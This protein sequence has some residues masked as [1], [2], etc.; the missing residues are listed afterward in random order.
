[1]ETERAEQIK[2]TTVMI[3]RHG[4]VVITG[5][6][7]GSVAR[8]LTQVILGRLLGAEKYG[9]YALGFSFFSIIGQVS[10]L[11]LA[12]G[13]IKYGAVYQS[14]NDQ[15]RLKGLL[16]LAVIVV[17]AVAVITA[18]F[19]FITAPYLAAG[20]F[21]KS[22][23]VPVIKYFALAVPFFALGMISAASARALQKI[24]DYTLI[25][26]LWHPAIFIVFTGAIYLIGPNI[27]NA[28]GAFVLAWIL[29]FV[30]SAVSLLK[31][32]PVLHPG[33][34]PVYETKEWFRF[35]IPVFLAKWLPLLINNVDKVI[36]GKL[37]LAGD[38]GIYNAGSKVAAQIVLFMQALNLIFAPVIAA[39][40]H[41][42]KLEELNALF[43]T[44]TY[45]TVALTLPFVLWVVLNAE[46]VMGLFGA[47]FTAGKHVLI[48]CCLAQFI[49][50][51]TG[52]LE[53]LLIMVRQDLHL[54]NNLV[55][56]VVNLACNIILINKYGVWGAVLT[57]GISMFLFNFVRLVQ[58]YVLYG[59][60]PYNK[61]FMKVIVITAIVTAV[62]LVINKSFAGGIVDAVISFGILFGG[63]YWLLNA[64]GL[65]E[66]DRAVVLLIKR[67]VGGIFMRD[68]KS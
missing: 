32:S 35:V 66:G 31:T 10:Q 47:E 55:L 18:F 39:Y 56:A 27:G 43:K 28:L 57:L 30:F 11:G 67:K 49:S 38:L 15:A 17:A 63:F 65:D 58:V 64:W 1:M 40:F 51:C 52:P 12:E 20:F 16:Q 42:R 54:I 14:E 37:A 36:L 33:I 21:E 53:Y 44:V 8:F 9:L 26:Y 22:E 68:T 61:K 45:W 29:V 60:F 5:S 34:V 19:I 50:V 48:W 6:I 7:I 4:G 41:T 59:L 13:I 3:A 24:I 62:A 23:L 2:K 25:Q 46:L